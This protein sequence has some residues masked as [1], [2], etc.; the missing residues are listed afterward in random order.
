MNLEEINAKMRER[1]YN[2]FQK[3]LVCLEEE[4]AITLALG[5]TDLDKIDKLIEN[6]FS[7]LKKELVNI[8]WIYVRY[9]LTLSIEEGRAIIRMRFSRRLDRGIT[10][11]PIVDCGA[12]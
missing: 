10:L 5:T 12:L 6:V 3:D 8:K 11:C 1:F 7:L 4:E 9:P 2:K